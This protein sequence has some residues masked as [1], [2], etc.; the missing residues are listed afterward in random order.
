[1]RNAIFLEWASSDLITRLSKLLIP[2][3][4]IDGNASNQP[5]SLKNWGN[6]GL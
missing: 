2:Y 1:M 5:L 3:Q 4:Y 6:H